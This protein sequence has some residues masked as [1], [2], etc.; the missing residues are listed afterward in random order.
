MAT[1]LQVWRDGRRSTGAIKELRPGEQGTLDTLEIMANM[2]REDATQ[3][4]LRKFLLRYIV[5]PSWRVRGHDHAAELQACF[6]FA[7]KGIVYRRDPVGVER[8]VDMWST[9]CA[10]S[11]GEPEGDCGIKSVFLATCFALL[12]E[13]PYF[14]LI[15]QSPRDTTFR[16]VY[17]ALSD[18]RHFDPTP[19]D[20]P[21][22]FEAPF[23]KRVYYEI[24][25]QPEV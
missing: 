1:E 11:P 22:G 21:A 3:P 2:V 9:L 14:V 5:G 10:L 6:E 12:G 23:L 19:E 17:V 13:I 20:E 4:D 25:P 16:H 8:V 24:F 7:Q 18:G 15:T